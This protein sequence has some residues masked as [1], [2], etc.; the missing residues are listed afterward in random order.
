MFCNAIKVE[1]LGRI[2]WQCLECNLQ[3]DWKAQ[4]VEQAWRTRKMQDIRPQ[5]LLTTLSIPDYDYTTGDYWWSGKPVCNTVKFHKIC[6]PTLFKDLDFDLEQVPISPPSRYQLFGP[7]KDAVDSLM[8]NK[9]RKRCIATQQ[10]TFFFPRVPIKLRNGEPSV[11]R[12]TL[13]KN[14]FTYNLP[15]V[16]KNWLHIPVTMAWFNFF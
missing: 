15:S 2:R 8:I 16:V 14:D 7:F 5:L 6:D 12:M 9:W 4:E 11:K 3:E 10:K 1:I 13:L